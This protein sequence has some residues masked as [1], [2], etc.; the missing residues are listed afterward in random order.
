MSAVAMTEEKFYT[1]KEVAAYLRV[2]PR[3]VRKMILDGEIQA[4]KVRDEYRI[5]PSALDDYIQK[6]SRRD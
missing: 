1:V 5:R 2:H 6:Q 3:T 4:I